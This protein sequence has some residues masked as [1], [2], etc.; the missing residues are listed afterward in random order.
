MKIICIEEHAGDPGLGKASQPA[1]QQEAPYM[2]LSTTSHVIRPRNPHRPTFVTL[3]EAMALGADL[4]DGRIK[5]MDDHGIDMQVVSIGVPAQMVPA[6]QAVELTRTA[7]D[8]TAKAIAAH[9]K[10][11]SGFAALP[12]QNPTAAADELTRAVH[13]LGLKGALI[14][15]R[16]GETFLDD[17]RYASVLQRL[18]ELK[19]PLYVHPFVPL[20][21]VRQAYYSGLP[22]EVTAQFSLSGWGWHHEA[23]VHALRL[24]LS[25]VFEKFPDLK[26]ISGHWGEMVPFYLA[27]LDDSLPQKVTGLSRTISETYKNNVWV[28]LV[29]AWNYLINWMERI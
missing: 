21:A 14:V 9:P 7:N 17:P 2:A 12:W 4:G 29:R 15:G 18:H 13:E 5:A 28:N 16:P 25:G 24:I 19:V 3:Q 6:E 1:L 10:R 8:R 20:P 11:L 23:G 27:R 26:V 22:P